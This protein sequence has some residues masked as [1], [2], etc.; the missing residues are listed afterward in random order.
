MTKSYRANYLLLLDCAP[1]VTL[2][3]RRVD[4]GYV[5][6]S[7]IVGPMPDFTDGFIGSF[8][9]VRLAKVAIAE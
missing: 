3:N 8:F 1:S 7:F 9:F 2:F 5:L 6:V 4:I